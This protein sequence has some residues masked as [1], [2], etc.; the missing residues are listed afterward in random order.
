MRKNSHIYLQKKKIE[1]RQNQ[2]HWR[3]LD[4]GAEESKHHF[5]YFGWT[6]LFIA[7]ENDHINTLLLSD[8]D[9]NIKTKEGK[10]ALEIA[11]KYKQTEIIKLLEN[12]FNRRKR[13][14]ERKL[15]NFL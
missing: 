2:N 11:K 10:T 6:P 14:E 15:G 1:Q 3:A 13:E 5:G 12:E 8:T 9:I 7:S 4:L